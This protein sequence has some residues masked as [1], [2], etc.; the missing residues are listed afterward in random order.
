M[1]RPRAI[2]LFSGIIAFGATVPAPSNPLSLKDAINRSLSHNLGLAA[3]RLDA[4]QATEA[5]ELADAGFDWRFS[6]RNRLGSARTLTEINSGAPATDTFDAEFGITKPFSSG[7]SLTLGGSGAR[8]WYDSNAIPD[9]DKINLGTSLTF[10]QPLLKG[11]WQT[12]NLASV[13][14]ARLGADRSRLQ[15][16]ATTL[17]LIRDT[18]TAYWTLAAYRSL[19]A[20]RESSLRSAE[21]LLAEVV[22]RRRL[23]AATIQEQLQAEADVANQRVSILNAKQQAD[24]ADTRLRS[25]LGL[26]G[27][28]DAPAEVVVQVLPPEQVS[29]I[30]DYRRWLGQVLAFDL[31]AQVQQS[32][33][34]SAQNDLE[35]AR[36]NDNPQLDLAISGSAN[37]EAN[38]FGS[39]NS[40]LNALP[41]DHSWTGAATLTLSFPL[42]F[43]DA[44]ARVRL[45]ERSRRKADLRLADI[46]QALTF[47][48]RASWRDLE[49]ARARREAAAAALELQQQVY[50]GE[51]SRYSSGVSDIPKIL[52]A[53]ASLDAAKVSWVS[54][55]LDARIASARTA[56]L[57]GT[58]LSRHGFTWD[59]AESRSGSG[60]G[61]NDTLPPLKNP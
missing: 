39:L 52:Q 47:T 28:A 27:T 33:V 35:A 48:A 25:L 6:L 15:F 7:G 42:G 17:D 34:E 38:R 2:Y 19:V 5:I 61:V 31:D 14:N 24:A 26:D 59:D 53:Q 23:G 44:E 12:V 55:L 11:A 54:A 3:S 16:R 29:G 10:T 43:R 50:E 46:R 49:A 20:L 9:D 57:D 22:E 8:T 41:N 1:K 18:E 36:M 40:A 4:A 13:V 37:G 30:D 32:T 60:V 56:R 21:S 51:R 58:L 45:A